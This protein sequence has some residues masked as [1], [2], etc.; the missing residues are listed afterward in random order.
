MNTQCILQLHFPFNIPVMVV[1]HNQPDLIVH[2]GL[3]YS[4]V[5]SSGWM[6]NL[7]DELVLVLS[8][9]S[10]FNLDIVTFSPLAALANK[11]N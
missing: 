1:T 4:S 11:T 7:E 3:F 10:L 5:I 2:S 6:H 8:D 9:V